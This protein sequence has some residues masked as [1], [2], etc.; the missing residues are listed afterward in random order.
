ML[1]SASTSHP[2]EWLKVWDSWFTFYLKSKQVARLKNKRKISLK[3][4]LAEDSTSRMTARK[5]FSLMFKENARTSRRISSDFWAWFVSG[6]C[7]F[8][9]NAYRTFPPSSPP[10]GSKNIIASKAF[11]LKQL[12]HSTTFLSMIITQSLLSRSRTGERKTR[13]DK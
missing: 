5:E 12:F 3:V 4:L 13:S 11:V 6:Q 9:L 10:C 8:E 2:V 7:H 1:S